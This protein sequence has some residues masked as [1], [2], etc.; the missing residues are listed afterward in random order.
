[1]GVAAASLVLAGCGGGGDTSYDPGAAQGV[2]QD[3]SNNLVVVLSDGSVWGLL[4]TNNAGDNDVNN[5]NDISIMRGHLVSSSAGT[6]TILPVGPAANYSTAI[7]AFANAQQTLSISPSNS[8]QAWYF[9]GYYLS[10]YNTPASLSQIQGSYSGYIGLTQSS[11]S[12]AANAVQ[13]NIFGSTITI[14]TTQYSCSVS[15]SITP[16]SDMNVFSVTMTFRGS[17]CA[18]SSGTSVNGIAVNDEDGTFAILATTS[19]QQTG[20]MVV[21]D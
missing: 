14:S 9:D 10:D 7:T 12:R 2:W 13:I 19:N 18:L 3:T 21:T 20:L 1:M 8:P 15:G 5:A 17:E 4:N 11:L 16:R 6:V